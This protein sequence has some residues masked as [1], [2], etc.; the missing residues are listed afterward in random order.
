MDATSPEQRIV[1]AAMLLSEDGAVTGWASLRMQGGGFFDGLEPDGRTERPV[2]LV[3]PGS[4]RRPRPGMTF[5]ED[6]LDRSEIVDLRGIPCTV[7]R[8][9]VFDEMRCAT[10]LREAVVT[11]DMAAAA[12]IISIS[13]MRSYLRDHPGWDGVQVTR[14][15]LDLSDEDSWSPQETRTRMIWVLEAGLPRPMTN[16]PV[17]SL[18]GRLLGYA[19]LLDAESGLVVEYDGDDHRKASRHSRDVDREDLFRRH[20]LE[21]THVTGADTRDPDRCVAR[22]HAAR[23]RARWLRP[24][25]RPWTL[26]YPDGFELELPLDVELDLKGEPD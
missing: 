22:F 7:A 26:A 8:R 1:E 10:T 18:S 24:S 25:E 2:P 4:R 15:A 12:R 20:H 14:Q 17:F 23:K 21:V 9:A 16:R 11:M 5:R 6:Q 19:D 3:V 13:R